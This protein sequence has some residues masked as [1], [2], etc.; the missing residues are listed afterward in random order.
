MPTLKVQGTILDK[1]TWSSRAFDHDELRLEDQVTGSQIKEL[2]QQLQQQDWR[3]LD[4]DDIKDR[5]DAFSLAIVAGR[6][7]DDG[8]AEGDFN[9]HRS[10][11]QQYKDFVHW[12][13]SFHGTLLP[14]DLPCTRRSLRR[15]P[16]YMLAPRSR[17][18]GGR[19][20]IVAAS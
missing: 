2:L 8:P 9:I 1:I 7:V 10:V 6:A 4:G 3:G 14:R 19:Y 15:T 20:I 11:Y 18:N 13:R 16:K 17:I 5:E 12:G